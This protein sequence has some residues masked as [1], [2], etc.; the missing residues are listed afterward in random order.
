ML[1][2]GA[3]LAGACRAV[4]R[5]R[6]TEY[7]VALH[8][9]MPPPQQAPDGNRLRPGGVEP[10]ASLRRQPGLAVDDKQVE[11]HRLRPAEVQ[12]AVERRHAAPRCMLGD[13]VAVEAE[14]VLRL[15]QRADP[16]VP[17][18]GAVV[19]SPPKRTTLAPVI[20]SAGSFEA[21]LS[22]LQLVKKILFAPVRAMAVPG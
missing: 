11:V 2:T 14:A 9:L 7:W 16:A 17:W 12:V 4:R 1:V 8:D 20:A 6:K 22:S 21:R 10:D 13:D 19:C 5:S 15:G 3:L 18:P